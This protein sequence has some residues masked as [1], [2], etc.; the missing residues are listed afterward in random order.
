MVT[1]IETMNNSLLMKR[2]EN[3][4]R[5]KPF[6]SIL[7][8]HFL[9][10]LFTYGNWVSMARPLTYSTTFVLFYSM[11][12]LF[13]LVNIHGHPSELFLMPCIDKICRA[14]PN[15]DNFFNSSSKQFL[16]SVSYWVLVLIC[17]KG[18]WFSNQLITNQKMREIAIVLGHC[19]ASVVDIWYL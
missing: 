15:R 8:L 3:E 4:N 17:V 9:H 10:D 18:N 13:V 7:A 12:T 5:H 2:G 11:C 1:F 16:L 14:K 6:Q 19:W